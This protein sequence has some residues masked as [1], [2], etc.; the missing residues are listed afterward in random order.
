MS[1]NEKVTNIIVENYVEESRQPAASFLD[2]QEQ[3]H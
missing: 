1:L 3:T 2:D